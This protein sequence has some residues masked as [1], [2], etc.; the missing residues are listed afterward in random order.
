MYTQKLDLDDLQL[1]A[2]TYVGPWAYARAKRA[3]V[4]L[5][6]E[7]AR[8]LRGTGVTI[9]AMHPGWADTPGLAETL[10]GF[11]RLMGP[12]LRT[13]A[14]GADTVVWLGADP[15][16]AATS[17]ALFLD[18]RRRPFDRVPGTR[19]S[20]ADRGRLWDAVVKLSGEPDPI[21]GA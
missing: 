19:L 2:G 14:E 7:W 15:A 21:P 17:G 16:A 4:A 12:F 11:H 18:R 3:Q 8:R 5:V 20:A 13:P 9:N 1:T 6:R 10:P